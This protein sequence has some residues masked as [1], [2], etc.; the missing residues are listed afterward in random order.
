MGNGDEKS[1][2]P[3]AEMEGGVEMLIGLDFRA[4]AAF[5]SSVMRDQHCG[6]WVGGSC[7]DWDCFNVRICRG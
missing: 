4:F 3:P 6:R 1:K 5:G 7:T 2:T